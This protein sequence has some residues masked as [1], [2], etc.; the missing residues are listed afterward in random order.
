[1]KN[2]TINKY[3]FSKRYFHCCVV[4]YQNGKTND[5]LIVIPITVIVA[6]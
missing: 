1:M 6:K 2:I 4:K 3:L 5:F